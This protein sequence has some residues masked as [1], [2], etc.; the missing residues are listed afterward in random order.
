MA[1]GTMPG[2]PA[3]QPPQPLDRL[4]PLRVEGPPLVLADLVHGLVQRFDEMEAV[5][6]QRHIRTV[7]RDRPDVGGAHVATG[8]GD[9]RF[10]PPAQPVVEEAV[11]GV[12]ALALADPQDPR[13]VQ[14]V[15]EGGEF[16]GLSGFPKDILLMQ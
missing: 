7:V 14:V 8:P 16:P 4:P 3:E 2:V 11:D 5:D 13:A 15:D 12:A 10:L 1:L 6:D 9:S